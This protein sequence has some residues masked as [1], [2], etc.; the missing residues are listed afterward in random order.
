MIGVFLRASTNTEIYRHDNEDIHTLWPNFCKQPQYEIII[1]SQKDRFHHL[2]TVRLTDYLRYHRSV[3]CFS[4]LNVFKI[5]M[6]VSLY[7]NLTRT[8]YN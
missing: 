3:D 4:I 7:I 6:K 5:C 2:R 8:W 1:S